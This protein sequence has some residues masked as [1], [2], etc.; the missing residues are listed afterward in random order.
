MSGK[1][2]KRIVIDASIACSASTRDNPESSC[3]RKFLDS[4]RSVC[5]KI[6]MTRDILDEWKEKRSN[7]S[8]TWLASMC[9]RRKVCRLGKVED[10]NLRVLV[11]KCSLTEKER[12]AIEDDIHLLEA[13]LATDLLI[14]SK[15]EE[16]RKAL[17]KL[18][19]NIRELR[20]IVW[21]NPVVDEQRE[22]DALK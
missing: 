16:M 20:A 3:C 22:G 19:L 2:S 1:T 15:D 21:I 18:A 17:D 11:D 13:A 5:H 9:A 10:D 12:K 6:V 7:Y 8:H 4:V 14:A